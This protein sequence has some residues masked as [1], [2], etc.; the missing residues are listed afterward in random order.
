MTHAIWHTIHDMVFKSPSQSFRSSFRCIHLIQIQASWQFRA[1]AWTFSE[2]R[3]KL[4]L[5]VYKLFVDT[6][7]PAGTLLS[8]I[9]DAPSKNPIEIILYWSVQHYSMGVVYRR[10]D[11]HLI[12]LNMVPID[13]NSMYDYIVLFYVMDFDEYTRRFIFEV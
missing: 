4:R 9:L 6:W 10:S 2:R 8:W 5:V 1:R 7:K 3:I 13:N 11:N 12:Y